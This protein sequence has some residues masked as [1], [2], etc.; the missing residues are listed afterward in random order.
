LSSDDLS[1]AFDKQLSPEEVAER[2]ALAKRQGRS[3]W[4]WPDVTV[5]A[6]A[7]AM[8]ELE[9]AV[10]AVLGGARARLGGE[11]AAIGVACYTSGTGPLLGWWQERGAI[12]AEPAIAPVLE[13]HLAHNRR[14]VAQMESRA[15]GL[16]EAL[17]G[18]GTAVAVLKGGHTGH[19]YFPHPATRPA[20]DIDLLVAPTDVAAAEAVL[21][22]ADFVVQSRGARESSWR[23]ADVAPQPRSLTLVHADDPWS[24]D[25]HR[26]LDIFVSA[27][28]PL[29]ALDVTRPLEGR[30]RWPP[31]PQAIVLDQ[32]ALLLHL[33]THAGAG[34]HNLTLLRLIELVLVVRQDLRA[35]LL[36]WDEFLVAAAR[37]GAAG[38]SY[39]ALALAEKLAPGTVPAFVLARCAAAA[40]APVRRIVGG[41]TPATAQRIDRAS[42][43]EHFMWSSGWMSR[44]RQLGADLAPPWR[45][46]WSTYEKRAWRLLRGA[47]SR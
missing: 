27:G 19:A 32:P 2:F 17:A 41:L 46:L 29:A 38:Y 47:V 45:M 35:R 21:S 10:R 33:A 28:A 24:I 37:A 11:R 9:T 13:L 16:V 5:S 4:L 22:A 30:R 6:W 40:P 43:T 7:A 1:G 3:A 23:T 44:A 15:A 12:S 18:Q 39:P 31:A 20:A 42:I 14:R 8:A 26:S 36:R 25:L 34:L